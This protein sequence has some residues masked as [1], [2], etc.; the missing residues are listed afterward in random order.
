MK[1]ILFTI[2]NFLGLFLL[3]GG[4]TYAIEIKDER[5]A[6]G[7]ER[8]VNRAIEVTLKDED[9]DKYWD[10]VVLVAQEVPNQYPNNEL[11]GMIMSVWKKQADGIYCTRITYEE[12]ETR[13]ARKEFKRAWKSIGGQPHKNFI[14]A[15]RIRTVYTPTY[16]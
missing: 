3:I 13:K 14:S 5:T 1:N 15:C 10:L 4:T 6:P 8:F 16:R 12:S 11:E 2:A 7:D 9:A